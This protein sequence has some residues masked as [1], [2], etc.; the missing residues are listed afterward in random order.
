[1]SKIQI[2]YEVI[3]EEKQVRELGIKFIEVNGPPDKFKRPIM[4]IEYDSFNNRINLLSKAKIKFITKEKQI[5]KGSKKII[6][7]LRDI[8]EGNFMRE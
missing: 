3:P 2:P 5:I 7:T 6:N 4:T 1:M 8:K